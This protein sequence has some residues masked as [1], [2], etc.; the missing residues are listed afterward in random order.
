MQ[1]VTRTKSLTL[2]LRN[3]SVEQQ[4]PVYPSNTKRRQLK[5]K[6]RHSS[7]KPRQ[8]SFTPGGP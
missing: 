1:S 5:M 3:E 6:Q 2:H 4:L 7:S 8:S